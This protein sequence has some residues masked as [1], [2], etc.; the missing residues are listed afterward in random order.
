MKKTAALLL[1]LCLLCVSAFAAAAHDADKTAEY[2]AHSAQK[3]SV[4]EHA[5]SLGYGEEW[6]VFALAR[7]GR[8]FTSYCSSFD[9]SA[10]HIINPVERE[11]CALALVICGAQKDK[12]AS[13]VSGAIGGQGIMSLVFGLHVI[14][15]GVEYPDRTAQDIIDNLLSLQLP[16]GGFALFGTVSDVDVSAMTLQALADFS[17]AK[18]VAEA[19]EKTVSFLSSTQKEDGGY[20][21]FGTESSESVSMVIIALSSLGIDCETDERFIKNG[22][23]LFGVLDRYLLSDGSYEHTKGGGANRLATVQALC[24]IES[25]KYKG[26]PFWIFA[27]SGTQEEVSEELSEPVSETEEISEETSDISEETTEISEI[28]EGSG[29]ISEQ[30]TSAPVSSAP[31]QT[32]SDESGESSADEN[33]NGGGANIKLIILC[34]LGALAAAALCVLII[35]HKANVINVIIVAVIFAAAAGI[36][37]A[38]DIYSKENYY[39][40]TSSKENVAGK[41]FI[42]VSAEGI[43]GKGYFIEKTELEFES[44]GTVYDLLIDA[45]RLNGVALD[46]SGAGAFVYVRGIDYLYEREHGDLSGWVYTVN[47]V[48]ASVGC[49]LYE[50]SDGDVVEW[51]YTTDG[52]DRTKQ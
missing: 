3:N 26:H 28:S 36:V 18:G 4:E 43:G 24:A 31:A 6:S 7:F 9:A 40:K 37:L 39:G 10:E 32:V 21:S 48:S 29:E 45:A 22:N 41:A 12:I 33:A 47:G 5:A 52:I 50:L 27:G 1:V 38:A 51:F 20:V 46:V 25:Y 16:D 8:G 15:N 34:V 44:G 17:D 11:R 30:E 23:T 19:V 42:S 14:A 2:L 13:F 49:A 35:K